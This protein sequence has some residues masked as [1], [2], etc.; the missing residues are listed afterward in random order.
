MIRYSEIKN[1]NPREIVLL[2]GYPCRW[3]KCSF[4]DYIKDNSKD[5]TEMIT[6]NNSV[7]KNVTGIYNAL[8]VINSGSVFELPKDTL[9]RIK[10][11]IEVKNIKTLYVESYYTYKDKFQSMRD[12]FKIKVI[13]KCGIET[14]DNNFRN[15]VLNKGI[16][17]D[18]IEE[19][20]K[21][22]DSICL[23]VGV[24]GQTKDMIKRDIEYLLE[25][26]P[27]GCINIFNN[28]STNIKEDVELIQWFK[29]NY[30]YLEDLP[31]VDV[32][33]NN[34]DFGVGGVIDK[35]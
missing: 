6:I 35:Y 3:S 16:Y 29:E 5:E 32:L 23:L 4:C 12:F 30:L 14:F 7:L 24:K 19:I 1:K 10:E 25:Y 8:E 28:N 2:K 27:Y 18:E 11:V 17:F 34:T 15:N 26:F 33:W 20:S 22:F 31:N 13:Y 9:N 21:Y